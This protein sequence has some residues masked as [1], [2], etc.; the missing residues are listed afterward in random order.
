MQ[1]H[2]VM[3]TGVQSNWLHTGVQT[4]WMHSGKGNLVVRVYDVLKASPYKFLP[5]GLWAAE[6]VYQNMDMV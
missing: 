4:N 6:A 3:H 2:Q 1:L 5:V